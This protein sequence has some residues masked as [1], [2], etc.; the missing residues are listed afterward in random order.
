MSNISIEHKEKLQQ[1]IYSDDFENVT[2]GLELLD[3]LAEDERDIHDVFDLT[4]KVPSTVDDLGKEIFDCQFKN[5]IKVWILG[6]TLG[7]YNTDWVCNLTELD[8]SYIQILDS[9]CLL[10]ISQILLIYV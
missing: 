1:L 2:Q 3:T 8:L 10:G 5:D 9:F 7:E 6:N 4:D